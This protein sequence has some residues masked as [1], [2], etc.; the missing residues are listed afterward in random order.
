MTVTRIPCEIRRASAD[1]KVFHVIE[2]KTG[3]EKLV[4]YG[5]LFPLKTTNRFLLQLERDYKINIKN[6]LEFFR[7]I[8]AETTAKYK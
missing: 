3:K 1:S 7:E 5:R 4:S 8:K 6:R 2:L